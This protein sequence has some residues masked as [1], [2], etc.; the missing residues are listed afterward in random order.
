MLVA[1][2]RGS[3]RSWAPQ[4]PPER[5]LAFAQERNQEHVR[6]TGEQ[7]YL[8]RCTRHRQKAVHLRSRE[9]G[10]RFLQ[11]QSFHTGTS[12]GTFLLFLDRVGISRNW[13]TVCILVL[14]VTLGTVVVKG[15]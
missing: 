4:G 5:I 14:M 15:G 2:G 3:V 13:A 8:G 6:V 7:V 11:T 12:G 9:R 1:C 10:W